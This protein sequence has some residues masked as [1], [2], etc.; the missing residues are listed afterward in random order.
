[1]SQLLMTDTGTSW[2]I[3]LAGTDALLSLSNESELSITGAGTTALE[4][5]QIG[6]NNARPEL[7]VTDGSTLSVTTTSGTTTATDTGNNAIHLRGDAPKTTITDGSELKV[8]VNS[9]A[10]RGLFLNGNNAE[11]TVTDSQLD[12]TTISGQTLHLTGI[13]PN[14]TLNKS[15]ARVDSTNGQRINLS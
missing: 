12:L 15:K 2:G 4:N 9:G 8:S 13:S 11:L 10:R 1:N 6:N 3:L 7:S 5:I 14:M